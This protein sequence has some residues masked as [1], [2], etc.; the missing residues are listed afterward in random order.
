MRYALTAL[1]LVAGAVSLFRA[2][3]KADAL[4]RLNQSKFQ[5]ESNQ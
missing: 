5:R 3:T 2:Q 4:G 1:A